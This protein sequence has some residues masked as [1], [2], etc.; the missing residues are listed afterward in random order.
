MI[1]TLFT[2][3]VCLASASALRS[4][5]ADLIT[6]RILCDANQN[7]TADAG[8]AGVAGALIVIVSEAGGFS[9]AVITAANGSFGLAIPPFDASAYRRDPLFSLSSVED[10]LGRGG[11]CKDIPPYLQDAKGKRPPVNPVRLP[12]LFST[13][14]WR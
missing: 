10:S 6:G 4:V 1:K 3:F 13:T 5:H 14:F 2:V 9:N 7:L 8:D 11:Y 12:G